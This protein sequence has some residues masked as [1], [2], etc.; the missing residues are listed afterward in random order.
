MSE[1]NHTGSSRRDFVRNAVAGLVGTTL[2]AGLAGE[3][4]AGESDEL[5]PVAVLPENVT[6]TWLGPAFW[7]NRVQD[8]RLHNG[9]LEC[10]QGG[11]SFE[12]RTVGLLTRSLRPGVA[13]GR[14]RVRTGLLTNAGLQGFGGF[15]L[16][17]GGGRLDYRAAALA[18][19][20]SGEG[21]GFMAVLET[22]GQIRFREHSSQREPLAFHA[23]PADIE[24]RGRP[25]GAEQQVV[26]DLEILPQRN[27]RSDVQL[28]AFDHPSGRLIA[29]AVRRGVD[30]AEL[31]GG[32]SLVSS[33]PAGAEGARWWFSHLESGGEKLDEH[34]DRALGP[35]L[36]TL[37]SLNERVLKLS[38]QLM[39]I[40]DSEPQTVRLEISPPGSRERWQPVGT[41]PIHPGYT[42]LFRVE[43]WDSSRDW[44]YRVLYAPAE[45]TPTEYT[46]R[47][48][49]DPVDAREL[50]IGLF[51]CVVATASGLEVA[52]PR[53]VEPK[54]QIPQAQVLGR[55]TRANLYFP[56]AELVRNSAQ[57]EPELL[58]FAGD[59]FYEGNPTRV[60]DREDPGL[61]YLY[62]WYLWMWSFREMTRDTP[63]IVLVD[64]H[65]VYHPNVWGEGGEKAPVGPQGWN[66]GG[67]VGTADFVNM[68]QRTQCSH[69]PDA[70]DPTPV[71]RGITVYYGAFRYGGVDFAVLEDRK[72]KTSPVYGQDLDVHEPQLLGARQERFLEEWGRRGGEMK[73]CLTQSVFGCVQTSPAGRP[74]LDFDSNGYPTLGRERAVRLLRDAGALILAGDQHLATVVR[75]GVDSYTDGP[76][77]FSGPAGATQ[78]QRWFE[79]AQLLPNSTGDRNTGDYKDAFGNKLRVLAVAN[80]KVSFAEYREHIK[81]RGQG[82]GDQQL[83]S[84]GYGIVR[85]DKAAREYVLECW[86]WEVDSRR[87]GPRQ[88]SG[89]PYRLPFSRVRGE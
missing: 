47:I 48:R 57:H 3:A 4:S 39:P 36:G 27:G 11:K 68:V 58:V 5:R 59:Q 84:E 45:G 49:R 85:V 81:G 79:P 70:Y 52:T 75:H 13:A 31:V 63:A 86:P 89:W 1:S 54:P 22:D 73:V 17:V 74:L 20:A 51:S 16:G 30:E 9:R 61:D 23:L 34:P 42:A 24:T 55:Y 14:L 69:N 35:V 21:G 40:S 7:G 41:A 10:T 53:T 78:W 8:W 37:Y 32:I 80:P 77:Q 15:L 65:D 88:F 44:D 60:A 83:K 18:Q 33:P 72:W 50:R 64:D 76:L 25:I 87:S 66:H 43:D 29:R 38:A 62:K 26:L 67:Y 12:V 19:Q 82:L 28:S 2:G 6:R 71:E 56:F 46:G